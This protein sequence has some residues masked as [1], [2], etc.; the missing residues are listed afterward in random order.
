MVTL[1]VEKTNKLNLAEIPSA[2]STRP[3][4]RNSRTQPRQVKVV[5]L[6]SG[7]GGMDMGFSG[8]F[9]FLR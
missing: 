8:G 2:G 6:F 4:Q 5:S 1:S 7:C 3:G 9:K